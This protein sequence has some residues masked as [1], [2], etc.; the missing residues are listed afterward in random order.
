MPTIKLRG[1]LYDLHEPV[2]GA[3]RHAE[4]RGDTERQVFHAASENRYS[5]RTDGRMLVSTPYELLLPLIGEDGI[6]RLI[7][8][9]HRVGQSS[10]R[11]ADE[12]A[13]SVTEAA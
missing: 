6:A 5:H 8:P 9:D 13:P 7:V 4:I 12:A 1:K 2:K 3:K 10:G 11:I